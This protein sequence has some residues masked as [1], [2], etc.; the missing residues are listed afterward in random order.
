MLQVVDAVASLREGGY[1][2]GF[3]LVGEEGGLDAVHKRCAFHGITEHCAFVGT[4]PYADVP[5]YVRAMDVGTIPFKRGNPISERS[6]PLKLFEYA[7]C[8]VPVISSPLPGVVDV[9][10]EEV[11]FA[12][13]AAAF[14]RQVRTLIE[15]P[16][17][18][19]ERG[20]ASRELAESF[21]WSAQVDAIE[22][23]LATLAGVD[24]ADDELEAEGEA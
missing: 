3:M 24:L 16:E 8:G 17:G 12:D 21:S 23:E 22:Q 6:L 13:D 7:A 14:A 19:A 15:D 1:D 20:A 5:G 18:R 11:L 9:A 2:V 10:S 4:V